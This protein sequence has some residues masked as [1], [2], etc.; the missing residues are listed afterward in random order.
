M[1]I[2]LAIIDSDIN[3]LERLSEVMQQYDE[4]SISIFSTLEYFQKASESNDF[5]IILFDPDLSE[6]LLIFQSETVP[7]CLCSEDTKNKIIYA[8]MP[9]IQKYQRI[10][11]IYKEMI[12]I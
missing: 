10:S 3:Y 12:K 1:N 2:R 9:C 6:Q 8:K 5:Q 11:N 7:I 4:I